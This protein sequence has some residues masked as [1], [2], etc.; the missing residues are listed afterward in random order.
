M[1][2][3]AK[4]KVVLNFTKVDLNTTTAVVET[5]QESANTTNSTDDANSTAEVNNAT[6]NLTINSTK[7]EAVEKVDLKEKEEE[8]ALLEESDEKDT[9]PVQQGQ[10]KPWTPPGVTY[11]S[12]EEVQK[13]LLPQV[14]LKKI[15]EDTKDLE[16][17]PVVRPKAHVQ[18]MT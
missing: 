4:P 14:A 2:Q 15:Q 17:K 6:A 13:A 16:Q 9:L 7:V 18:Q 12:P 11:A 1:E 8:D 5:P 3:K 10:I